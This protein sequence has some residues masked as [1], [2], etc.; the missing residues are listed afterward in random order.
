MPHQL[1]QL[2][3]NKGLDLVTP[4][5]SMEAGALRECLNYE[6]TD[7]SGIRR[8]DGYERYDGY[9]NG[10]LYEFYV[11]KLTKTDPTPITAGTL[12]A[13][14]SE[15]VPFRDVAVVL[16][17]LGDD[18]YAVALLAPSSLLQVEEYFLNLSDGESFL[19]LADGQSL[20]VLAETGGDIGDDFIAKVPGTPAF[21]VT[22]ASSI[23]S[24]KDG[25]TA[26]TYIVKLREYASLLRSFV[27][28]A[29][30]RI[31]GLHYY[32]D[33]LLAAV[34]VGYLEINGAEADPRPTLGSRIRW[35]G[36]VYRVVALVDRPAA[37]GMVKYRAYLSPVTTSTTVDDNAVA[38]SYTGTEG[39]IYATGVT[40]SGLYN[41]EGS[42]VAVLGYYNNPQTSLS[43]GFTYLPAA[44]IHPFT[45]GSSTSIQGPIPSS[46]EDTMYY[47]SSAD[48]STV[49]RGYLTYANI[50]SGE[51]TG[52]T[53]VGSSQF[54]ITEVLS[55]DRDYLANGDVLYLG[56]P[57]DGGTPVLTF[58]S[59]ASYAQ[60][61]G[62]EA[63]KAA[64]SRY[65]WSNYNFYGQA[66]TLTA[67]G[68]TGASRAFWAT[69]FGYGLIS[70]LQDT[71]QDTPKYLSYHGGKMV[72]GYPKGSLL[73]SV[74]G[75]PHN[76]SGVDG[77]IEIAVGDE[78]TGLLELPGD[79]LG[80]F[81][82]RSIRKLVGSTTQESQLQTI[83]ANAGCLDYTAQIVGQTAVYTGLNGIS[84]LEQTAAY[85]DFVG[86]RVS[87]KISTWLRPRLV[88][89][90]PR[91]EAVGVVGAT[92]CRS[93]AQYRL[94]LSSGDWVFVTFT[95]DGPKCML[96]NYNTNGQSRV[97]FCWSSQ[98]ADDGVERLHVRWDTPTLESRTI[99]LDSGW[100]FD[101]R[102]FNYK[103]TLAH[104]FTPNAAN[105]V[106]VER[107]RAFG[108]S[109]G[110]ATV[111]IKASGIEDDFMQPYGSVLR[112]LSIPM[113][114]ELLY[115]TLTPVTSVVDHANRG[116]GVSLKLENAYPENSQ[117][118]E[119]PHIYQVLI[120]H[121]RAEGA[122]DA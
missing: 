81:C 24:G 66:G 105:S 39:T 38:V 46:D 2:D 30:S 34:D 84:T 29:P 23:S 113:K 108:Q 97:P 52:G 65:V 49:F 53:A 4:P 1:I 9:P 118:T 60:L 96:V 107:I 92:V 88:K 27:L 17:D 80:V 19:E 44:A 57:T 103:A 62:T 31:A 116:L 106:G 98:I 51:W 43:R 100:G 79:A 42:E 8:I 120:L 71:A 91:V 95:E 16:E 18:N 58:G 63:L 89:N 72:L 37:V 119:P 94:M 21:T 75:E 117:E 56:D 3:L 110:A 102:V 64:D 25:H 15:V 36:V 67:Y 122:A 55:G 90:N 59:V 73:L 48:N 85:G 112:D 74:V 14:G 6:I 104:V 26:E 115:S 13:R 12:I 45:A 50:E 69:S 33:R 28:D 22:I 86:Q 109:Y 5:L 68:A 83:A 7:I 87:D 11:I 121:V 99:E 40:S 35:N 61:A 111:N 82:R 32:K 114:R 77:A 70:G 10:S 20:L 54:A 41:N 93:K 47:V 78:L 101:G 76:Y